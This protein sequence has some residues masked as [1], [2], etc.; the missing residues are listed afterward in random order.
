MTRVLYFV[1]KLL[2]KGL[3]AAVL[4]VSN[5]RGNHS[6]KI[7][8][9]KS[10]HCTCLIL[11]LTEFLLIKNLKFILNSRS[12]FYSGKGDEKFVIRN[13]KP[14]KRCHNIRLALHRPRF[15]L[16]TS[17]S[18]VDPQWYSPLLVGGGRVEGSWWDFHKSSG[19]LFI[20]LGGVNQ[21]LWSHLEYLERNAA[22]FSLKSI[23]KG[24]N[25]KTFFS[26]GLKLKAHPDRFLMVSWFLLGFFCD[27][28]PRN[29][30][31]IAAEI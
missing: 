18:T 23:F 5:G 20:S 3:A 28:H 6:L 30:A 17:L 10:Y 8:C 21:K 7:S 22:S 15:P 4:D 12:I 13:Y 9:K 19:L 31:L 25:R 1:V 26:S 11:N 27:E 2:T 24:W 14:S 29:C 16:P